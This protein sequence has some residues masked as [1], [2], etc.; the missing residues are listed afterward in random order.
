MSGIPS[1]SLSTTGELY[2]A[3]LASNELQDSAW[4]GQV[5]VRGPKIVNLVAQ[6]GSSQG[7]TLA[8][9]SNSNSIDKRSMSMGGGDSVVNSETVNNNTT[10]NNIVAAAKQK[11]SGQVVNRIS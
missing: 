10:V 1:L 11:D 5:G 2:I 9:N 3:S 4:Y 7:T 8:S 6:A